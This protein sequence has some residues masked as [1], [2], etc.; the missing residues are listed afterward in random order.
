MATDV[1]KL[2]QDAAYVAVG[3]G[4]LAFQ[5]AQVARREARSR[6]E[7]QVHVTRQRLTTGADEA[8]SSAREARGRLESVVSDVRA[9]VDP[10]TAQVRARVE[11]LAGQVHDRLP[12]PL[13]KVVG[14]GSNQ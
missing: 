9:L 11:P 2:A 10:V 7:S 1:R 13:A 3:V 6:L 12:E 4:V 14:R 5:R 8:R